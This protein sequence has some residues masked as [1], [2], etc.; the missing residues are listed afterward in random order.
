MI[1]I[2][3]PGRGNTKGTKCFDMNRNF[4]SL[5]LGVANLQRIKQY[6]LVKL[7]YFNSIR[8]KASSL[9]ETLWKHSFRMLSRAR[10]R[11]SD[12]L[13]HCYPF[14]PGWSEAV[15]LRVL[16]KNTPHLRWPVSNPQPLDHKS[17][18]LTTELS[19]L[20]KTVLDDNHD[21]ESEKRQLQ[22]CR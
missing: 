5:K 2:L 15:A 6:C 18:A 9:F 4:L 3:K 12:L 19:R 20:P 21:I 1:Y 10:E 16:P 8:M 7:I 22:I 17:N 11:G 13:H 14:T